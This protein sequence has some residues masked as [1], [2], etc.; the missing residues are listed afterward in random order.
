MTEQD[1]PL[2]T[3]ALFAYNQESF[4]RE[5]VN[6]ALAQTY[7]PMEIILSDDFSTDG[8]FSIMK[9]LAGA[10]TG[11]NHIILNRNPE[12]LGLA[13]HIARLSELATGNLIVVAAG[14]DISL[15]QRTAALV[16]QWRSNGYRSGSYYSSLILI[17][18]AGRPVATGCPDRPP[19]VTL[20]ERTNLIF[21]GVY[22]CSHAWTRDLSERFGPFDPRILQED[23]IIPLRAALSGAIHFTPEPLVKYRVHSGTISRIK[24]NGFRDRL[25]KMARYWE[26]HVAVFEQ[27]DRD[28]NKARSERLITAEDAEWLRQNIVHRKVAA[29][30]H[31]RFLTSGRVGRIKTIISSL[32]QVPPS[33]SLKWLVITAIPHLY[34]LRLPRLRGAV[35]T[36][37]S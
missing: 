11:P 31:F 18:E 16:S 3:F 30:R 25:A 14:D 9:E 12:N 34:G 10:Y 26:G 20:A 29:Q 5:A 21:Q 2:V 8:T 23:F 7:S 19:T 24:H 28:I 27:F 17:D 37:R 13:A 33:Q 4:I 36:T 15:P 35:P 6:A 1:R 22:G 32:G